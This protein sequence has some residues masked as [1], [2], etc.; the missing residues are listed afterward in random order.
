MTDESKPENANETCVGPQS[1]SA[2]KA[3]SCE[4]C[5][6]QSVC[7]TGE[8]QGPD[9]AI[10]QIKRAMSIV[11]HKFL[12]LSGKGGVGKSTFSTQLTLALALSDKQLQKIRLQQKPTEEDEDDENVTQVGILDIDLCGPSVPRMF[13]LEGQQLH[14]SNLGWSPAYYQDNV[15]VISI[16]FMLPNIDDP[17]IWRGPKKNGLIKQ[18]L[19]DVY[20]GDTLDY[21]VI[22]SPPGTSDEHITIVQYLKN[23]GLDGAIIIT[24]PQDV[25]CIDVRREINFCKKVG[26]PILGLVENMSGFVCPKCTH[27]SVIFRATSGGGERLA[28]DYNIP[29]LG[30]LP[31]D[32]Q[33]MQACETG[34]SIL[35]ECPS[36]PASKALLQLVDTLKGI[37]SKKSL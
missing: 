1:E 18:F 32:P 29:F 9:P 31:L 17:V 37:D 30:R 15:A 19:K 36:S 28:R 34:K 8:L 26:I 20:W 23:A 13:G 14:Q 7:A 4:G 21:L 33:V 22:D 6:N 11:R 25:A 35:K 12:I 24:T 10:E 16:G 5:P 27:E 3:S 2:G